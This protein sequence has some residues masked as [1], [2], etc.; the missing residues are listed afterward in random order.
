[1]FT[2][3]GCACQLRFSLVISDLFLKLITSRR[4]LLRL[5]WSHLLILLDLRFLIFIQ[6]IIFINLI[7][8][9]SQFLLLLLLKMLLLQLLLLWICKMLG[10]FFNLKLGSFFSWN[11]RVWGF[12]RS[13]ILLL[14]LQQ[15]LMVLWCIFTFLLFL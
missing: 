8:F 11:W 15:L 7:F 12:L 4:Y 14:D 3:L 2:L 1:M 6:I 10:R 13:Q 5:V 9:S